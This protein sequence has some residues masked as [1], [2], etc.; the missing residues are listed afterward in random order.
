[1]LMTFKLKKNMYTNKLETINKLIWLPKKIYFLILTQK[2]AKSAIV[3]WQ[4]CK[5]VFL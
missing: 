2:W 1:M 3:H 4:N 5:P